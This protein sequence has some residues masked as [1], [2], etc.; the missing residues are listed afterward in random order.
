M[1][2]VSGYKDRKIKYAQTENICHFKT[3]YNDLCF[4]FWLIHKPTCGVFSSTVY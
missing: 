3:M 1:Q 4:I 2:N